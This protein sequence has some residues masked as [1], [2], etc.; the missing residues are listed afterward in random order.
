MSNSLDYGLRFHNFEVK[1]IIFD[2]IEN[3]KDFKCTVNIELNVRD[4]FSKV[5]KVEKIKKSFFQTVFIVSITSTNQKK[6]LNLQVEVSGLFELFGEIEEQI[7]ENFKNLSAPS[8]V[9]PFIRAFIS[10]LTLQAG[11]NPI[12]IPTVNFGNLKEISLVKAKE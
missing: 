8:I 9:Y 6:Y 11:I 10:N 12:N 1:K 5:K 3:Q 2:R 4:I 7:V